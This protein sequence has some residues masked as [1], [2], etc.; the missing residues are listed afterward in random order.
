MRGVVVVAAVLLLAGCPGGRGQDE[1]Q[2]SPPRNSTAPQNT[3]AVP[4][5]SASMNPVAPPH[6]ELP[7][8]R[9][10]A[11]TSVV[12]V[13]LIE[14]EIRMPDT[15]PAGHTTLQITNGGKLNHNFAIE[16]PGV[17]MKLS[18]DLTRGDSQQLD[19]N[20]HPGTYTVYCPVDGHRG[21]GMQRTLTVK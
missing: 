3:Q 4:E 13:Q 11:A 10:P 19:V 2:V 18:S 1:S 20:L 8:N 16:G 15:L 12:Q 17:Q 5:N 14:Y 9:A 21:K 6:K 7:G